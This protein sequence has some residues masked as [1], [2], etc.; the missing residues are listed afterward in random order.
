[1]NVYR[2]YIQYAAHA[3][4]F[5]FII[6]FCTNF[7][8]FQK[9]AQAALMYDAVFV[10]VEAFNKLLRKKPDQF[11]SYTMR[12]RMGQ[13][14]APVTNISSINTTASN[15]NANTNRVLDCNTSKGWVNAWLVLHLDFNTFT[16]MCNNI[17]HIILNASPYFSHFF[18]VFGFFFHSFTFHLDSTG[19]MEIRFHATFAK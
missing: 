2:R 16:F 11:R 5:S 19:N 8:S 17:I 13:I 14:L 9:K 15:G 3:S 12:N 6:I 18:I 4:L 7:S 10:L 1:M